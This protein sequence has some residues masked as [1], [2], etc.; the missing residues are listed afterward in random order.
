VTDAKIL[1]NGV[2]EGINTIVYSKIS[3]A[4]SPDL[5][6][7]SIQNIFPDFIN[8]KPMNQPSFG[9][10]SNFELKQ[11][12]LSMNNFLVL[13]HKQAILD[14]A[15]DVLSMNMKDNSTSFEILRQASISGKIAFN[16][17]SQKPL[18]GVIK[19]EMIGDD[20]PAWIEAATWHKGRDAVPRRI[21]DERTMAEDGDASTWH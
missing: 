21:N 4:E 13:L 5:V 8:S 16:L 15:L 1:L 3:G 20:L 18:G 7:Q 6:L 9:N 10:P 12:N 19:I 11:E 2:D 14:T 17:G